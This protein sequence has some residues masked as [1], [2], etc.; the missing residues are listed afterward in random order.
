MTDVD[1]AVAAFRA[2]LLRLSGRSVDLKVAIR[3][4]ARKA[5]A[6]VDGDV[7]GELETETEARITKQWTDEA[8]A[9]GGRHSAGIVGLKYAIDPDNP[10]EVRNNIARI[11][12]ERRRRRKKNA[13]DAFRSRKRF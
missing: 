5:A 4:A 12:A 8:D 9:I 6:N 10:V 11:H 13:S 3:R 7:N 2:E 1:I